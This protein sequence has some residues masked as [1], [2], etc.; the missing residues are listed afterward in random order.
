M[1]PSEVQIFKSMSMVNKRIENFMKRKREESDDRNVRLYYNYNQDD[2]SARTSSSVAAKRLKGS[3]CY[4]KLSRV[5]NESGPQCNGGLDPA[6]NTGYEISKQLELNSKSDIYERITNLESCMNIKPL[7]KN[8]YERLKIIEERVL[9]LESILGNKKGL[10]DIKVFDEQAEPLDQLL[11]DK[12]DESIYNSINE[13]QKNEV[14]I[15][16]V[17][18]TSLVQK[19]QKYSA[20]DIERFIN[21]LKG[22][23][24]N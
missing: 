18:L 14:I 2:S 13:N 4:V 7:D 20:S 6:S 21:Q 11:N 3:E 12:N 24:E 19:K 16:T 1:D 8:F 9:L 15:N 23:E 22:K 17:N 10:L 5:Y